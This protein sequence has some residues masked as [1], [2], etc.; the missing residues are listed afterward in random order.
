[1]GKNACGA[2][3]ISPQKGEIAM[4]ETVDK[5]A[6]LEGKAV[7]LIEKFEEFKGKGLMDVDKIVIVID[8]VGDNMT[9]EFLPE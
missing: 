8:I 3:A 2:R 7:E 5:L 4:T 9:I 1:M 6:S